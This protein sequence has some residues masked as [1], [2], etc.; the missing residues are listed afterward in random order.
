MQEVLGAISNCA[1]YPPKIG[2]N[3]GICSG[4]TWSWYGN[5]ARVSSQG[6]RDKVYRQLRVVSAEAP[7]ADAADGSEACEIRDLQAR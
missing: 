4:R 7:R 3:V 6:W 1:L 2:M 5:Q